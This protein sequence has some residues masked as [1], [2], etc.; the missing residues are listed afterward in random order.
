MQCEIGHIGYA[1]IHGHLSAPRF[2]VTTSKEVFRDPWNLIGFEIGIEE[3]G[4]FF[5]P[6]VL[7]GFEFLPGQSPEYFGVQPKPAQRSCEGQ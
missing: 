1:L 5:S 4:L 2:P 6:Q 7:M 3:H